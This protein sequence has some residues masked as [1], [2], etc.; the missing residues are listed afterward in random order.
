MTMK[1]LL[2]KNGF[3][4]LTL[5]GYSFFNL[6]VYQRRQLSLGIVSISWVMSKLNLIHRKF[7]KQQEKETKEKSSL[8]KS[9][10]LVF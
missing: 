4:R 5:P 1:I 7:E 9:F 8:E 10:K 6:I 2:V 3:A